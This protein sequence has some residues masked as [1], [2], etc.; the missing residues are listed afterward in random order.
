MEKSAPGGC[1]VTGLGLLL[2]FAAIE[3][4]I[5]LIAWSLHQMLGSGFHPRSVTGAVAGVLI[6]FAGPQLWFLSAGAH[7]RVTWRQAVAAAPDLA[8][9]GYF[10]V[11]WAAPQLIGYK[12]AAS[13]V[14]I[15]VLEF[16]IIHASVAMVMVPRLLAERP[17]QHHPWLTGR[18]AVVGLAVIYS[19]FAASISA[20]FKSAWLFIGFWILV[21]NKFIGD[22]LAPETQAEERHRQHMARWAMS[23]CLY[24]VLTFGSIFVPVPRLGAMSASRGAGIWEQYPEQAV[25]MGALYFALLGFC[26]LY[27]AFSKVEVKA[28]ETR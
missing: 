17:G 18:R 16:I 21:G 22:W 8:L 10:I 14:G 3:G 24:L 13:L 23:A 12:A 19:I 11:G 5:V 4:G 7:K 27:G 2:G 28:A 25:M 6:L 9:A 15:M 1:A 26:E 20:A